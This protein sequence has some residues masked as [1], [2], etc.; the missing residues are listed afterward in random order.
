MGSQQRRKL[1]QLLQTSVS[2]QLKEI[3]A[4]CERAEAASDVEGTF[5][6]E[7]AAG[8]LIERLFTSPGVAAEL[9]ELVSQ[10]EMTQLT[11]KDLIELGNDVRAVLCDD[12][13]TPMRQIVRFVQSINRAEKAART[14]GTQL[15]RECIKTIYVHLV[16]EGDGKEH[17]SKRMWTVGDE[18]INCPIR[19]SGGEIFIGPQLRVSDHPAVHLVLSLNKVL[20]N[21]RLRF[22]LSRVDPSAPLRPDELAQLDLAAL[23]ASKESSTIICVRVD[24][25]HA[26]GWRPVAKRGRDWVTTSLNARRLMSRGK[27]RSA[28]GKAV[29]VGY[30]RDQKGHLGLYENLEQPF[31]FRSLATLHSGERRAT[32]LVLAVADVLVPGWTRELREDTRKYGFPPTSRSGVATQA[33][34]MKGWD[35][36]SHVEPET[37][38]TLTASVS[39]GRSSTTASRREAGFGFPHVNE[40]R[41]I[42]L[43][44]GD[45]TFFLFSAKEYMH[46]TTH[47]AGTAVTGSSSRTNVASVT[48]L[49]H[50]GVLKLEREPE[51]DPEGQ[52]GRNSHFPESGTQGH[53]CASTSLELDPVRVTSLVNIPCKNGPPP[54]IPT[55]RHR[56]L[57]QDE[58]SLG[59]CVFPKQYNFDFQRRLRLRYFS[60]HNS[61]VFLPL[62]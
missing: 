31:D 53:P 32:D 33:L 11:E 13:A 23:S 16:P 60:C 27:E 42:S 46:G 26:S 44:S 55:A 47:D 41:G 21:D 56:S 22:L 52:A 39:F 5:A 18:S 10:Q 24:A 54:P 38:P 30:R 8:E 3:E 20:V 50:L 58:M 17:G 34:A 4:T 2:S 19:T 57:A 45:G 15:A 9:E 35:A 1:R 49:L 59:L 14:D 37:D 7:T 40:D 51:Q 61:R 62:L 25:R 36:K 29:G 48:D 12:Q 28:V 43:E 6:A